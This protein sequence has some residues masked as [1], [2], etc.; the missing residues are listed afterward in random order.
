MKDSLSLL[1]AAVVFAL[2]G[3]AF[4]HYLGPDAL[5]TLVI[6]TLVAVTVDNARLRRQLRKRGS[7]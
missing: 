1:A 7:E 4:W 5:C 3:W 6:L 2:L